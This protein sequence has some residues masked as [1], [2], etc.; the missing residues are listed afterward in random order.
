MALRT[1]RSSC[2]AAS[3]AGPPR[4]APAP[5]ACTISGI[6]RTAGL[7]ALPWRFRCWGVTKLVPAALAFC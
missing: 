2:C 4:A 6:M 5:R 3:W 7:C 1:A